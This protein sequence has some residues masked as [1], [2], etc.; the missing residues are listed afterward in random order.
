M[1]IL[2]NPKRRSAMAV[3]LAHLIQIASVLPIDASTLERSIS[4]LDKAITAREIS[5]GNWERW[6]PA[7]AFWVAV[8]VAIEIFVII[9]EYLEDRAA[10][11]RA[12]ILPPDKPHTPK[13]I[14]EIMGA[15]LV[16]A[17]VELEF[18]GGA[19]IAQ[20][21]GGLRSMNAQL[22]HESGQLVALVTQQAGDAKESA[23]LARE[24]ASG[25]KTLADAADTKAK[26]VEARAAQIDAE[27][28][29]TEFLMSARTV[30][31]RKE[32]V[33]A[34]RGKS[35]WN[36]VLLRS[37]IGDQEGYGLCTLLWATAKE[38]ELDPADECG[39]S[40]LTVPMG[41]TIEISGPYLDETM[42]LSSMLITVGRVTG[43]GISSAIKGP[44]L[45]IFV[46]VKG[47]VIIGQARMA[48]V[49]KK[50]QQRKTSTKP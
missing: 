41:N 25:A 9:R 45:T 4:A 13:L 28:K 18:W 3:T 11:R 1:P 8:G 36:G 19:S 5:S 30:L 27:L 12:T 23:R 2:V 38:A 33:D 21:N 7:F 37:Y 43:G 50:K 14:W 31:N 17:G 15:I 44:R 42:A 20:I 49:P 48:L 47:S 10:W 40:P 32:L 39:R 16:T 46:G 24:S 26:Q 29:E 35:K 22:R 34:M 6:L